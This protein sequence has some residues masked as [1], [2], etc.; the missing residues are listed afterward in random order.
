MT[1]LSLVASALLFVPALL[2]FPRSEGRANLP[3]Q[4]L[5]PAEREDPERAPERA[6]EPGPRE[7]SPRTFAHA[8][9]EDK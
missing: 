8:L 5:S 7:A 9:A 3:E 2:Y 4:L 6:P 1:L